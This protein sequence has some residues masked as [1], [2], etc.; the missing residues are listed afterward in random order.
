MATWY[1]KE[2]RKMSLALVLLTAVLAGAAEPETSAV[3][4][5][6]IP[7]P[8]SA[9]MV[10]FLAWCAASGVEIVGAEFVSVGTVQRDSDR[11]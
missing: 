4:P 9:A 1:L 6:A 3:L 2:R 5:E 10:R 7:G 11:G 8:G